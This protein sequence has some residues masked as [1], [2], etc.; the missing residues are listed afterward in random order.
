[1]HSKKTVSKGRGELPQPKTAGDYQTLI[2]EINESVDDLMG[3]ESAEVKGVLTNK[4]SW[5]GGF[6]GNPNE[7]IHRMHG[8]LR[9]MKEDPFQDN[10]RAFKKLLK[11]FS[12]NIDFG[13]GQ[14]I[15]LNTNQE[16]EI[17]YKLTKAFTSQKE[18]DGFLDEFLKLPHKDE[19]IHVALVTL[20]RAEKSGR[21]V[22]VEN[23]KKGLR[24][25]D[26]EPKIKEKIKGDEEFTDAK[27]FLHPAGVLVGY[28]LINP[29][30]EGEWV[31]KRKEGEEDPGYREIEGEVAEKKTANFRVYVGTRQFQQVEEIKYDD[32]GGYVYGTIKKSGE[33]PHVTLYPKDTGWCRDIEASRSAVRSLTEHGF[34]N[35]PTKIVLETPRG[36]RESE[37]HRLHQLDDKAQLSRHVFKQVLREVG[38]E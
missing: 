6:S 15:G 32:A 33:Q 21:A 28:T 17:H 26:K 36:L 25:L 27:K 31:A 35:L 8:V 13:T 14:K 2:R 11:L 19:L 18:K 10:P 1:M 22:P 4:I 30:K 24:L 23:I 34:P 9:A 7:R 3:E 38:R 29:G 12:Y 37:E 16:E 20:K 5:G